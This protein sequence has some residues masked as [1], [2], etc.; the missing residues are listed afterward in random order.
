LAKAYFISGLGADRQAF[1]NIKLPAQYE[2]VFLDWIPPEKDEI[3]S[4]YARRFSTLIKN[5]DAFILI[6]LS[7]GG[8]LAAEISRIRRPMKTIIISSIASYNELPWYFK[9]AGKMK[10]HR[11]IPIRLLKAGTII[12]NIMGA[13]SKE[14]KAIIYNYAKYADPEFIR[15]SIGAIINWDQQERLPGI[16]HVHGTNDHLLPIKYTHPD[17]TIKGGGHLMILNRADEVNRILNEVLS[18]N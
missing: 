14:D 8:M 16:I 2:S 11:S 15:W 3:L 7:F 12:N 17:Y 13:G 4:S 10:L 1:K 9:Q 6:G 18:V 5:D